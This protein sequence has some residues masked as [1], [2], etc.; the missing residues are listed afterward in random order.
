MSIPKP[1]NHERFP[2]DWAQLYALGFGQSCSLI[3]SYLENLISRDEFEALYR[4]LY[5][6]H[7]D[8]ID[9]LVHIQA[10]AINAIRPPE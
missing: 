2:D 1:V 3:E 6:T 8:R 7:Y 5:T 4:K 9:H 10:A